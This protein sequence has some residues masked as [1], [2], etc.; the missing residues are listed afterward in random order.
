MLSG[1]E[2]VEPPMQMVTQATPTF[3]RPRRRAYRHLNRKLHF[4]SHGSASQRLPAS[5]EQFR[6]EPPKKPCSGYLDRKKSHQS[7]LT[8]TSRP[9]SASLGD[10]LG[11]A[12]LLTHH[13]MP[14]FLS[15]QPH[16]DG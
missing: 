8:T 4:S 16:S 10:F 6:K 5:G 7:L 1:P 14:V 15:Q 13:L 12:A 3:D 11:N 2:N 9:G